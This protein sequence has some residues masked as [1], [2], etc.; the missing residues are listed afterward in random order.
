MIS[1]EAVRQLTEPIVD[2]LTHGGDAWQLA[3][4]Y[5]DIRRDLMERGTSFE[6]PPSQILSNI[7]TA[8]DSYAPD[9]TP[10]DIDEGQLR[11]ELMEA[12]GALRSTGF[13]E[14]G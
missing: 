13:L 1:R 8:M 6:G 10:F 2:W 7:D 3:L 4:T 14:G 9:P 5:W 11:M 12:I